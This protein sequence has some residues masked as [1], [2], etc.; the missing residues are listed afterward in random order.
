MQAGTFRT[1]HDLRKRR[2]T[3]LGIGVLIMGCTHGEQSA[4]VFPNL[5]TE[6]VTQ[7][8]GTTRSLNV[9][10]CEAFGSEQLEQLIQQLRVSHPDGWQAASPVSYAPTYTI[11]SGSTEILVL[12]N[13]IV[14]AWEEGGKHRSATK[15][16][17]TTTVR[18]RIEAVCADPLDKRN[19]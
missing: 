13:G 18:K 8:F 15:A 6:S 5:P 16:M 14:L 3:I 9:P 4:D 19:R 12:K 10:A 17:D 11:K 7:T 2:L 1:T